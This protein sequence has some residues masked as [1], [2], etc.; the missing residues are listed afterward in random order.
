MTAAVTIRETGFAEHAY[1]GEK[2]WHGL[3]QALRPGANIETWKQAAG[4]DWTVLRGVVRYATSRN[5]DDLQLQTLPEQHVLFRSDNRQPL[6]I[7]S[8]KY[9]IVQPG[10]VLEFFRDLTE[11]NGF[12]LTTAGT[13]FDGRRF[14]ALA[15]IGEEAVV[16]GDD[17]V[18]GYL[19]LSTSCDGTLAT[20]ARFTTVRVVC[21]N[22]LSMALKDR[23]REV[24]IRHTS[25]FN[26]DRVKDD[27]GLARGAFAS[28][29]RDARQLAA[30]PLDEIT[31]RSF[32]GELLSD[33]KTVF[34]KD[35]AASRPFKEIM[36][37]YRGAG[38]GSLL[39]GSDGSA[40]GL[41]N[42]VTEYVD[43][44]ARATSDSHRLTNAWFGKGDALKSEAL[45]RALAL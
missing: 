44:H 8:K 45:A 42:A 26:A 24:I 12:Q 3:G 21:N 11:A 10:E 31:A 28:F 37:L 32:V 27:L 41:V 15:A 17:K 6:G 14:W 4:M 9:K 43:H 2:P 25:R 35:V 29:M 34:K 5:P 39:D 23:R 18:G 30:K 19:L 38:R 16:V 20:T 33:T 40:W 1:V 22:T 7:V 13:L 36:N